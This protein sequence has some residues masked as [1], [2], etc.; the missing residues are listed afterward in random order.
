MQPENWELAYLWDMREAAHEIISFVVNVK[1]ADFT[2]NKMIRY[3]VD[4]NSL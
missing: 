2:N 4:D 1:Y 3:A